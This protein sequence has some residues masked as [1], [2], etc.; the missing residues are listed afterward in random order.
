MSLI[1]V[2]PTA[3]AGT[4][5]TDSTVVVPGFGEVFDGD[6]N[7]VFGSSPSAPSND[8]TNELHFGEVNGENTGET[9]LHVL[10]L[11]RETYCQDYQPRSET[12]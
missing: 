12:S 8:G 11:F 4:G 1:D 10:T 7:K 3:L 2:G 6:G 9:F 5:V